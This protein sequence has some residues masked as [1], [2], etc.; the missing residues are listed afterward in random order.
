MTLADEV[1]CSRGDVIAAARD[2]PAVADS[3]EAD[4]VWMAE[5]PLL[6]GRAYLMKLG[7]RTVSATVVELKSKTDVNTMEREPATDPG[8][9]RDR[10]R[11]MSVSTRPS[12]SKPTTTTTISAASSSS[13]G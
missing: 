13:T 2:A 11:C 12:P 5:A 8:A 3:F 9:Q 7:A 1:D 4:L 10:P 6:T